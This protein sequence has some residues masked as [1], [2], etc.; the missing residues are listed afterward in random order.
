M[1]SEVTTRP[2]V[3][4]LFSGLTVVWA[5]V[6]LA[7]AAATFGLLVTLP[8]ATFVAVKTAASIIITGLGVFVTVSWSL[9][10]AR[11][12]GLVFA[13]LPVPPA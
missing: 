2:A 13:R 7:S 1:S 5:V 8:L 6:Y 12:E 10:T 4:R 11:G 9:R 3:G